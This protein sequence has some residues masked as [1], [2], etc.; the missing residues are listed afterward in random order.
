M[1]ITPISSTRLFL[2]SANV[3]LGG[4]Y[5][6]DYYSPQQGRSFSINDALHTVSNSLMKINDV[7]EISHE[8]NSIDLSA[9]GEA[10]HT[11]G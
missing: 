3:L 4:G 7:S 8:I 9:T 2:D 6:G 11:L 1:P 10:V 5:A